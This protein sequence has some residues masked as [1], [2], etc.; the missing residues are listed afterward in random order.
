MNKRN[1]SCPRWKKPFR[2]I[3]HYLNEMAGVPNYERY[4]EHF[5]KNHPGE[6]PLSAKEFHRRANDEK[7]GGGNIRRCC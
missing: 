4:L 7:Y 1:F 3:A 5:Q 2:A 6:K